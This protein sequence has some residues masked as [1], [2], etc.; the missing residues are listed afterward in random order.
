MVTVIPRIQGLEKVQGLIARLRGSQ[1]RQAYASALNDVAFET[2][3]AMVAELSQVFDRPTSYITRS[4]R[5][6]RATASS[7]TARIEPTYP[8][9]KGIDP[10]KILAAQAHGGRRANKRF[11]NALQ[12]IGVMQPGF[13]AVPPRDPFPGSMDSNG[14]LRGPFL[15]QLLAYFQAFGE[16][17]YR[18]NMDAKGKARLLRGKLLTG[19]P[20]QGQQRS[21]DGRRYFAT[22]G[23][24]RGEGKGAHFAPGIWAATGPGGVDVRPVVL[25]VR[26]ARYQARLD[27]DRMATRINTQAR[28]EAR[29]RYRI[30]M[31]AGV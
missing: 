4:P 19:P 21:R 11:E 23:K 29:M 2:R 3:A 26:V 27:M 15:V 20:Q 13:Q 25:F 6:I 31:A 14:N 17:G 28:L 1:M 8:G 9:G 24:L 12:R 22:H 7:L 10:Q 5:V 16:Q 30:R 18:A